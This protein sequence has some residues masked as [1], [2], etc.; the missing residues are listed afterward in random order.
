[1][2]KS[3]GVNMLKVKTSGQFKKDYKKCLK[4]G[5]DIDLLKSI[6]SV[7]AIP[8]ELPPKNQ[9]HELKG[10][11]KSFSECHILPDW[12]LIYRYSEEYLELARTGTHADLFKK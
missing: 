10:E 9:A 4:R 6:V 3:G 8:S 5:L 12:L 11:Y 7:L 1:M 2:E